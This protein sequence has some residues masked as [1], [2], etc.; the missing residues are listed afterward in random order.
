MIMINN[1][2]KPRCEKCKF[3]D[4]SAGMTTSYGDNEI[5]AR[6]ITID[7]DNRS[8]CDTLEQSFKEGAKTD[9]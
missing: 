8:L 1:A 4:I 7:C 5:V 2:L 6:D 3:L 9:E